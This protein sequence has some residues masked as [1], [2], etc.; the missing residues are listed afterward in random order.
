MQG[1]AP[2]ARRAW[3]KYWFRPAAL[4]DI[5]AL[6]VLAV[7][8]QLGL[9]LLD[10][11]Y[12]LASLKVIAALPSSLYWPLPVVH[13]LSLPFGGAY[14][15][16]LGT[17]QSVQVVTMCAGFLALIGLFTNASLLVFA[18]GCTF[19]QGWACS[20][21]DI[22]HPEAVM[23]VA[24]GALALGP[25]GK[26]LSVDSWLSRK[27]RKAPAVDMLSATSPEARWPVL[28]IQWFFALMYLSAFYAKLVVGEGQWFNG[29]SLQ[30]YLAVDGLR[31][32]S[33][34]AVWLAQFHWIVF[35]SSL[36]VFFFQGTF[37]VSMLYPR[38]KWFY[39]PF[40]MSLHVGIYVLLR[41]PFFQWAVLYAVFVPWGELLKQLRLMRRGTPVAGAFDAT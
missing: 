35:L 6:R 33:D 1:F 22:H 20:F 17:M 29:Y 34:L 15:L 7:G 31:W 41:A 27:F 10:P 26:L 30:F 19:L 12:N 3:A 24:L 28:L 32:G 2:R 13:L 38:L 25:S 23:M 11:R 39:V 40:G 9:L 36:A 8:L 14:A 18:L 5:A 37:F 4:F 16:S 21:D